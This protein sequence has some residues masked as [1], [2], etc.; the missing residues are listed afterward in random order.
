MSRE[1]TSETEMEPMSEEKEI[2]ETEPVEDATETVD[3]P[4]EVEKWKSLS[5]KNE[6]QAK[7][8]AQAARELEELK[9]SQLSDTEKLVESTKD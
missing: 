4:A 1:T 3:F 5:R 8:N 2:A 6:Q 9:R 7:T